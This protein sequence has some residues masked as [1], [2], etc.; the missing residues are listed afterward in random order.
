VKRE[1]PSLKFLATQYQTSSI[2]IQTPRAIKEELLY[3]AKQ[4]K[5][6][7]A[8]SKKQRHKK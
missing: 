6:Y 2:Q 5:H 7:N 8:T 4:K 3:K 1:T